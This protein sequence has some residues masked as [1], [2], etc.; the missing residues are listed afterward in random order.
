MKIDILFI[1]LLA[2]LLLSNYSTSPISEKDI[3]KLT[4]N[5]IYEVTITHN[6]QSIY[7]LFCK[8][9]NLVGT[10][11]QTIRRDQ[12]ILNYFKYFAKLP[13]IKVVDKKY[14]ISKVTNNV[15][16]NTAFITW[17][18]DSLKKPIVARMTFVCKDNCIYQLHSSQ[19]PDLN[20][21]LKLKST[22]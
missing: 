9:G 10:V 8:E 1:I 13:G 18:W 16:I 11:S 3:A 6:P 7:K 12:D 15:Y 4:D 17:H 2:I 19:L 5:F 14:S 20:P 22:Y 21:A